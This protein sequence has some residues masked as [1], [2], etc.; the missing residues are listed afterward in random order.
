MPPDGMSPGAVEFVVAASLFGDGAGKPSVGIS[1]AETE[2][3]RAQ[4]TA[5]VIRSRFMEVLLRFG[6]ARFLT[7]QRI[8]QLPEIV[9]RE[10]RRI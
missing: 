4:L 10:T 5:S 2:P 3:A 9:A 6:D 7:S 1:P 8:E